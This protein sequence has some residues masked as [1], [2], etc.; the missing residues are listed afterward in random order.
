MQTDTFICP[1]CDSEVKFKY[2]AYPY[3][4]VWRDCEDNCLLSDYDMKNAY[5]NEME[6]RWERSQRGSGGPD[7]AQIMAEARKLK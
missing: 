6:A 5:E 2:D 3:Q 4:L 7:Y 1:D